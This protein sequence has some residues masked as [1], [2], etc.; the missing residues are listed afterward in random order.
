MAAVILKEGEDLDCA[1]TYK[2]VVTYLP[3]YARP[4]FIRV[5]VNKKNDLMSYI[6]ID[7]ENNTYILYKVYTFANTNRR[8][9]FAALLFPSL[10]SMHLTV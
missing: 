2:Q 6:Y 8:S 3:A 4:R 7:E 1:F 9:D 5:Q 10:K